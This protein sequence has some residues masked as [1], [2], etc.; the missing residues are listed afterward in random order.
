VVSTTLRPLYPQGTF[1]THCTGGWLALRVRL[2]F[3]E[4]LAPTGIRHPER[5]ARSESLYLLRY[6]YYQ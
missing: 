2:D 3:A 1:S 6:P 4:S 5:S